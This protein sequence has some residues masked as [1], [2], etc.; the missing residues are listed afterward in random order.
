VGTAGVQGTVGKLDHVLALPFAGAIGVTAVR[1]GTRILRRRVENPVLEVIDGW[2]R[3]AGPSFIREQRALIREQAVLESA[4]GRI[5][6]PT[7]VVVGGRDRVV[8]PQ[9]QR[10]LAERIPGARLVE[11][12]DAGHLIPYRRAAQLAEIVRAVSRG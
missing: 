4:L 12:P 9:A 7:T 10:A 8:S 6:V 5:R 3:S 2:G 11:L 1:A